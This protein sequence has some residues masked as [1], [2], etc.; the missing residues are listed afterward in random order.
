MMFLRNT[1]GPVEQA[2]DSRV[3]VPHL[4]SSS[5]AKAHLWFRR[6]HAE[7]GTAPAVLPHQAVPGRIVCPL[8]A[9]TMRRRNLHEL[10]ARKP[11][12]LLVECQRVTTTY[13]GSKLDD[14]CIRKGGTPF[15]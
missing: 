1:A 12:C 8:I 7:A 9:P 5:R 2:D 15:L 14:Q 4:V 13:P 6:V 11:C 10:E 3:D